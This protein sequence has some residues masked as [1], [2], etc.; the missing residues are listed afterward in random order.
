[1]QV[2]HLL[3]RTARLIRE[4]LFLPLL[5][6]LLVVL[7]GG[8]LNRLAN[9]IYALRHPSRF[10]VVG[11][12]LRELLRSAILETLAPARAVFQW[13]GTRF[14][15]AGLAGF[16][17]GALLLA[18]AV[19]VLILVARG[20]LIAAT[21]KIASTG[22]SSFGAALRAGWGRAWRLIIIASIPPIPVTLGAI[23]VVIVATLMLRQPGGLSFVDRPAEVW[24]RLG[25]APAVATI[26][27]M[28]PL[29]L[30]SFS[31]GLLRHLADRACVLENK[32]AIASYRRSWEVFREHGGDVLLLLVIQLVLEIAIWLVLLVPNALISLCA[33]LLL[34]LWVVQ[35][36]KK[37]F[38]IA[39]WTLAWR[40]WTSPSNPHSDPVNQTS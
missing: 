12:N 35:G 28:L 24:S 23:L 34:P 31:L 33:A 16:I 14:G 20:G 36:A 6:T 5:G 37:A 29:G 13:V 2:G 8:E 7:S 3:T 32:G 15:P 17:I 30:I 39:L 18:I 19:G 1:M 40:E 4:Y 10:P 38:F 25:G 27:I 9:L 21:D 26:C 11:A 22:D